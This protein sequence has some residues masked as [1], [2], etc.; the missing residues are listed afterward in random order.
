ML[1]TTAHKFRP[2]GATWD[3]KIFLPTNDNFKAIFYN[4][5]HFTT[6]EMIFKESNKPSSFFIDI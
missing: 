2:E 5:T 3:A 4:H 6:V 1:E